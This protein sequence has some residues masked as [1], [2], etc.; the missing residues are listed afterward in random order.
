MAAPSEP[1]CDPHTADLADEWS[2]EEADDC[3]VFE[4]S[5]G[6]SKPPS[7]APQHTAAPRDAA[8]P[9]ATAAVRRDRPMVP[10]C[11]ATLYLQAELC[12]KDTLMTWIA[13]RNVAM[14]SGL[15][16][17]HE[18]RRWVDRSLDIFRQI[19]VGLAHLHA[20]SCAHRDVKPSNIL[21][22]CDGN[23]RLGDFGLAKFLED[24]R[25]CCLHTN[26][27]SNSPQQGK[28][29]LGAAKQQ[30]TRA[31]GTASYASPEQLE[32]RPCGVE[33]DVYALGM[34][35]A[36]L[37]Y[38]V[39]T[40][41]ERAILLE[42]LRHD[43]KILG[44]ALPNAARLAV[45]MTN[46]DPIQR[47]SMDEIREACTEVE[48]EVRLCFGSETALLSSPFMASSLRTVASAV[49]AT[50]IGCTTAVV[51]SVHKPS[52]KGFATRCEKAASNRCQSKKEMA[53][54]SNSTACCSNST[55]CQSASEEQQAS[56]VAEQ[57]EKLPDPATL[58]E[59]SFAPDSLAAGKAP[60][61]CCRWPP[62]ALLPP[63]A[64][65]RARA[66]HI[67]SRKA[68][69]GHPC[70]HAQWHHCRHAVAP[71]IARLNT[72]T[73]APWTLGPPYSVVG[74]CLS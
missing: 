48:R 66:C 64:A 50:A 56:Q 69:Q 37:L 67:A 55:A 51:E 72:A 46:P 4:A 74:S 42:G 3:V 58:E 18:C 34:I 2:F 31:V 39:S 47:P 1:S 16:T 23:V 8:V 11:C 15:I 40:H 71:Q 25:P 27:S 65:Q 13:Q 21:F 28:S 70:R 26:T 57:R 49:E 32:G 59:L 38:P 45:A 20:Q 33:T 24:T 10:G 53:R 36:E 6:A 52:Q 7:S 12:R 68:A 62:F 30:H 19:G 73:R 17:M 61:E 54:C 41:M 9:T 14:A 29:F 43:R 60:S 35:L 22:G 63:R 44:E 5:S